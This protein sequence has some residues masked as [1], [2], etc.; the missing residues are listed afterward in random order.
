MRT[1]AVPPT[2]LP[3]S[4]VTATSNF[5]TVETILARNVTPLSFG[6]SCVHLSPLA[7][8]SHRSLVLAVRLECQGR[9]PSA[10]HAQ[11][12]SGPCSSLCCFYCHR[13]PLNAQTNA[14]PSANTRTG[15]IRAIL[16]PRWMAAFCNQVATSGTFSQVTADTPPIHSSDRISQSRNNPR[17]TRNAT[18]ECCEVYHPFPPPLSA[19]SIALAATASV[20]ANSW[21]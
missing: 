20:L 18:T 3:R 5:I 14:E 11:I 7:R 2:F 19:A 15:G 4:A 10:R 17:A 9:H 6:K 12:L 21:L 13:K 1:P 8:C 16:T